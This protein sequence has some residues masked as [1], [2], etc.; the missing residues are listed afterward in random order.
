MP[1]PKN[2]TAYGVFLHF[3]EPGTLETFIQD[4]QRILME[5]FQMIRIEGGGEYWTCGQEHVP[6]HRGFI[7]RCV[8]HLFSAAATAGKSAS[9]QP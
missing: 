5:N 3:A 8:T 7:D 2:R 9:G 4:Y 6:M 1:P